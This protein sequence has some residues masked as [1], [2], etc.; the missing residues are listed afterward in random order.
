MRD[1]HPVLRK[2]RMHPRVV[3]HRRLSKPRRGFRWGWYVVH[4]PAERAVCQLLLQTALRGGLRLRKL[5]VYHS[6]TTT[7]ATATTVA[8]VATASF[9]STSTATAT[10]VATASFTSTSTATATATATRETVVSVGIGGHLHRNRLVYVQF[11]QRLRERMV[12][13]KLQRWSL[14]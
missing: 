12:P 2:R 5:G 14:S 8:T 9:T 6:T 3:S 11:G 10:T 4:R 7:F 1:G 13:R